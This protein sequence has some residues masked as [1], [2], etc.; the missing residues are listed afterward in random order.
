M[1]PGQFV[2]TKRKNV[3][4]N[5]EVNLFDCQFG[6]KI[7]TSSKKFVS[8]VLGSDNKVLQCVYQST[9]V[10]KSKVVLYHSSAPLDDTDKTN[11]D[12]DE[13]LRGRIVSDWFMEMRILKYDESMTGNETRMGRIRRMMQKGLRLPT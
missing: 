13:Q 3:T 8:E 6:D 12:P 7:R 5:T 1:H 2:Y 4:D 10:Q 11:N 9:E